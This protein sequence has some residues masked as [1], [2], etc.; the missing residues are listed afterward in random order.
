MQ[1]TKNYNLKK[2]DLNDFYNVNDFNDNMD[3]IDNELS[4]LNEGHKNVPNVATNDQ[5]P[6]YTTSSQ[7][8]GLVSGEKMSVAFG[9]IAKAIKDFIDHL[10][11]KKNPHGVTAE[12][13]GLGKVQNLTIEDQTPTYTPATTLSEMESGEK[14]GTAFGKIA[15]AITGFISHLADKTNPHSVTKEQVGLGNVPNVV[16][17]DQTPTYTEA[18]TLDELQSGEKMSVSFGKILKAIKEFIAHKADKTNP[19]AVTASQVGLGNVPNVATND[20]TPTYT[21]YSTLTE[22]TSGEKM[23]TAFGKIAKAIKD[24]IAHKADKSN[25]HSVTAEQ[26]KAVQRTVLW[27]D[28]ATYPTLLRQVKAFISSGYTCGVI[29]LDAYT[30]APTDIPAK[31]MESSGV[32]SYFICKFQKH[33]YDY[34]EV[35]LTGDSSLTSYKNRAIL[36]QDIWAGDWVESFHRYGFMPKSGGSVSGQLGVSDGYGIF[37]ADD[38]GVL[39]EQRDEIGN[40]DNRRGMWTRALSAMRD[41][42]YAFVVFDTRDGKTATYALYGAHNKPSGNYVGDSSTSKRTINIGGIGEVLYIYDDMHAFFVTRFGAFAK[43]D[44][45]SDPYGLSVDQAKFVNG[46][47]TIGAS[48]TS[49][50]LSRTTY[51][52]QVL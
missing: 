6:T 47:L 8:M 11:N 16:T 24:L 14:I 17:N 42:A 44:T 26:V 4:N 40:T 36:S 49:L 38:S 25:P 45:A 46:V 18:T 13:V 30:K 29:Q 27:W 41:L 31:V 48:N 5:T 10:S 1:S 7:L 20:Q 2:P 51:Y 32:G 37:T 22:L 19:H 39:F 23:G 21:A 52:Y 43:S 12:Q 15:R 33:G 50:N 28:S 3:A 34:V 9:K 35:E